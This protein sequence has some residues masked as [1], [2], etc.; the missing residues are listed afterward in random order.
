MHFQRGNERVKSVAVD[1]I[2]LNGVNFTILVTV[3]Q[4]LPVVND[5]PVQLLISYNVQE[6]IASRETHYVSKTPQLFVVLV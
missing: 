4:R 3:N 5:V 2:L 1:T 6:L